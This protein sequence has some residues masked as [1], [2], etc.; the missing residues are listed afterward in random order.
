MDEVGL[1]T[2]RVG[3]AVKKTLAET[4]ME[5]LGKEQPALL[6]SGEFF[7][8]LLDGSQ[9]VGLTQV[10]ENP[11]GGCSAPS[12]DANSV[13]RST[14]EAVADGR[15]S[16]HDGGRS[17]RQKVSSGDGPERFRP[18]NDRYRIA[19]EIGSGGMGSVF[20]GWDRQLQREVAIKVIREDLRGKKRQSQRFL[21]EA[22]IASQLGHPGVLGIHDF[23]VDPSGSAYI[24]MDLITGQTLEQA[25][26]ETIDLES[27]RESMLT[28]FYQLCQAM[29]FAHAHGVI[30]RDLKPANI[31]VGD[32]GLATVLDWGLAKALGPVA[33]RA[34]DAVDETRGPI[35]ESIIDEPGHQSEG[36][37]DTVFGTVMGTPY[38]LAPEQARGEV[39]DYRADVFSLGGILCH[40]L[41]GHP[42]FRGEKLFDVFQQS[43][44]GDLSFA[45][46]HLDRCGA[47]IPVV[48]LAKRCLDPD[49]NV[50]PENAGQLVAALKEYLESG[51]RRAEEELVR[52]FDLSLDMFCIANTQGYFW[53]LNDNFT[54]SLG[55]SAQELTSV[56]FIDFVHPD[57][58]PETLDE[59]LKLSRGVPTIRFINRYRHKNGHY[60]VLEW[61][62]RSLEAEGV[63][64]AVARDITKRIRLESEKTRIESDRLR[65]SEIVDSASDAIIG[66]DLDGIVQSWN[67]GAE[68]LFGYTAAEM[69]GGRIHK[70][71]P[72]DHLEEEAEILERIRRGERVEHF[73]TVRI[74]QAGERI[75]ISLSVSP[76]RDR[77]GTIIGASKIARNINKQRTL[78][79]ELEKSRK[80][81][82]DIAENANVPLHCVNRTGTI[83]W[84]ND[85]EL[86]FLG[87][88]REEYIGQ[89]IA[90]FHAN[91]KTIEDIF[92]QLIEGKTLAHYRARLV[93]K[94]GSI[95]EVAIYSSTFR[96]DGQMV[97][98]RCF[99]IDVG[100]PRRDVPQTPLD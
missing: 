59:I 77:F 94:D 66:K 79:S 99:T 49:A 28:T 97:H 48:R 96:E 100:I 92:C 89:P 19:E 8:F 27:K 9:S 16:Q 38:Y 63:I 61:T 74:D 80:T 15:T 73:E 67:L 62:A 4:S 34:E 33:L 23:G 68:K 56:P 57:D 75:D 44:Q 78:E 91:Q 1:P 83:L 52:F 24:I 10:I 3:K 20:L 37:F 71:I 98:T 85:A 35:S 47:P 31:M 14:D 42:P 13:V 50:R 54:R 40:L 43:F 11:S 25:I 32:Y 86:N 51:Q 76:I 88:D 17:C 95:K 36:S 82:I 64:Y 93:A 26:E 22:R 6:S 41:T 72:P 87:Y 90:K 69:V 29:A 70:I 2:N 45:F 58:R 7:E 12:S 55:Y 65:L 81:I 60:V 30:H 84:A 39:V 46:D 18:F 21:R 53:R 5:G